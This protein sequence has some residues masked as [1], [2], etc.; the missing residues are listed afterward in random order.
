MIET[1]KVY[2][3]NIFSNKLDYD[4]LQGNINIKISTTVLFGSVQTSFRS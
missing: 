1:N 4:S 3:E 2:L